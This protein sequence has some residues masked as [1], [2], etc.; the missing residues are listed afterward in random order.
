MFFPPESDCPPPTNCGSRRHPPS[1]TQHCYCFP[2]EEETF[3]HKNDLWF[4]SFP[5]FLPPRFFWFQ[6]LVSASSPLR[7]FPLGPVTLRK[8]ST[9]S[10]FLLLFS[11]VM[12]SHLRAFRSVF[13]FTERL[14]PGASGRNITRTPPRALAISSPPKG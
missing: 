14:P 1:N 8:S 11:L 10:A 6:S 4:R 7:V 12:R 9:V 2:V 13:V 3:S 5:I